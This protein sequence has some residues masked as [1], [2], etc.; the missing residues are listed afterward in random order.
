LLLKPG[1]TSVAWLAAAEAYLECKLFADQSKKALEEAKDRLVALSSHT[2]E[3]GGGV[4]V[5][6][7]WRKGSIDY[8]TVPA[9]AGIDLDEYRGA[10]KEEVRVC[11]VD[12]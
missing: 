4:T 9:L 8:S 5:T 2:S 6:R 1:I 7:C 10:P 12:K 3:A 11:A